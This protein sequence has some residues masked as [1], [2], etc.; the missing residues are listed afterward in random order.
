[1]LALGRRRSASL[2]LGL[3]ESAADC[4][5]LL[6]DASQM[7]CQAVSA[8]FGENLMRRWSPKL[9]ELLF[10]YPDRCE[11]TLTA[12]EKRD[13]REPALLP[14]AAEEAEESGQPSGWPECNRV[15]PLYG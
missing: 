13:Y 5:V 4:Y 1:M 3:R 12:V 9:P 11:Q 8:G 6:S 15:F 14:D 7:F 10:A 2:N